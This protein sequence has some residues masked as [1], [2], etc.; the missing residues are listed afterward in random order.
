VVLMTLTIVVA[1]VLGRTATPVGEDV[2][3]TPA[4][5]LLG[6]WLPPEP[7]GGRVF[8]GFAPDGV[9]LSIVL[10]GAA[11]YVAGLVV[12]RRR[13]DT[14]P[15]GR[16]ISWFVGLTIIAWATFG[17]LGVYSGV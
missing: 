12:L 5:L 8:V 7:T 14:W 2:L 13:N 6:R 4:E 1:V 16:T 15:V 10:L 9:G 17:G 3:T 11:L